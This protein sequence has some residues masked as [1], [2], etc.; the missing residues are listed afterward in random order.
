MSIYPKNNQPIKNGIAT[1]KSVIRQNNMLR[2][3][4]CLKI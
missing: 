3:Y 1:L 4:K 2:V